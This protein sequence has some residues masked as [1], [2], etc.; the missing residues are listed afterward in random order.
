MSG[1]S[2]PFAVPVLLGL[3]V[4]ELSS[5]PGSYKCLDGDKATWL[6]GG[7]DELGRTG[8]S[9]VTVAQANH[10]EAN[11]D[12]WFCPGALVLSDSACRFFRPPTG[13]AILQRINARHMAWLLVVPLPLCSSTPGVMYAQQQS[14]AGS[15]RGLI[16]N[17]R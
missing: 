13:F 16:A 6:L 11:Y 9:D 2:Y 4:V 7:W 10:A 17:V 3:L 15:C 8:T 12:T 1:R 5:L 14:S